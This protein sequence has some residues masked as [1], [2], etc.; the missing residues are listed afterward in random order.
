MSFAAHGP[1][2]LFKGQWS[3]LWHMRWRNL[4]IETEQSEQTVFA[5]ISLSQYLDF[6]PCVI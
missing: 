5:H 2:V 3:A 1:L 4:N 6:L